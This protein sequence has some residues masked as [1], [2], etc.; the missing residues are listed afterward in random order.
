MLVR[1]TAATP[2]WKTSLIITSIVVALAAVAVLTR[3]PWNGLAGLGAAVFFWL[4]LRNPE[5]WLRRLAQ[6]CVLGAIAS[7]MVP[8]VAGWLALEGVGQVV[9]ETTDAL[10]YALLGAGVLLAGLEVVRE[11]GKQDDDEDEEVA[12]QPKDPLDTDVR[13]YFAR[14]IALHR[15]VELAGFETKLRA[16][17][18]LKDLYVPLHAMMDRDPWRDAEAFASAVGG[19]RR[20]PVPQSLRFLRARSCAP[21]AQAY[22]SPRNQCLRSCSKIRTTPRHI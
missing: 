21:T 19:T 16:P 11:R 13:E 2:W 17:I 1:V 12:E 6:A 8:E 22:I 14:A 5:H 10:A 20:D 7:S 4:A 3:W 9:F 18:R 15:N